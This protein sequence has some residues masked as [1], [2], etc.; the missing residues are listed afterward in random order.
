MVKKYYRV[1]LFS[2]LG[3]T[4]VQATSFFKRAATKITVVATASVGSCSLLYSNVRCNQED[5]LENRRAVYEQDTRNI[6]EMLRR[7][8]R[9]EREDTYDIKA[10]VQVAAGVIDL[11]SIG[12]GV[13][14]CATV[15]WGSLNLSSISIDRRKEAI[16]KLEEQGNKA[17][18]FSRAD[19]AHVPLF[20]LEKK[21]PTNKFTIPKEEIASCFP[22][23]ERKKVMD[24]ISCSYD[25]RKKD[26]EEFATTYADFT[27]SKEARGFFELSYKYSIGDFFKHEKIRR[28]FKVLKYNG[29]DFVTE[30]VGD[31]FHRTHPTISRLVTYK[32]PDF[33]LWRSKDKRLVY[34][35]SFDSENY[36]HDFEGYNDRYFFIGNQDGGVSIF[37]AQEQTI[38][39]TLYSTGASIRN[40]FKI[41]D[42]TLVVFSYE[43][44]DGSLTIWKRIP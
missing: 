30:A 27:F 1:V 25:R 4:S 6:I 14:P 15:I 36:I 33:S 41:D 11:V 19:L 7:E 38:K 31:Y 10:W 26:R 18:T 42:D 5:Y 12:T 34:T 3:I 16:K 23:K 8:I 17:A 9:D 20:V 43:C 13:P 40:I 35:G 39:Y 21:F 22:E 28:F 24:A 44:H 29:S 32:C 37:D 2:F